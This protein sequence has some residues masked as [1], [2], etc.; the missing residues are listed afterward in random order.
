MERLFDINI[1]S[2]EYSEEYIKE[3]D[4]KFSLQ[5]K[6]N[7]KDHP[8]KRISLTIDDF[9]NHIQMFKDN[10]HDVDSDEELNEFCIEMFGEPYIKN[11]D[12]LNE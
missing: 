10:G 6:K 11:D 1:D 12:N 8:K 5:S 7:L 2:N 4:L 3:R 9:R